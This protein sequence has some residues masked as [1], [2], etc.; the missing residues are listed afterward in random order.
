MLYPESQ[1][2]LP[3]SIP[4][5]ESVKAVLD[6]FHS[7]IRRL[8]DE[9]WQEWL[10]LPFRSRLVF[11][12]RARAVLVFDF[13][14]RRA[15]AEFENDANIRVLVKHRQT[16]QFMFGEKVLVRFK[17]G[18]S[19]GVGSNIETQAVLDFIDPQRTIP[20]LLSDI[21]K[22]EIC[23]QPD[24]IGIELDEV[25]VV[26]RDRRKRIWAYPIPGE[27]PSAIVVELPPQ[28]PDLTPPVV[29]PRKKPDEEEQIEE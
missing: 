21:M 6:D 7:R 28:K 27:K 22:V 4:E 18:N 15:Q 2:M 9:A 16:V 1:G 25:A 17:K 12:E 8:I 24:A 5:P 29:V 23:Y 20:G 14:V 19:K 26:A 3:M 10:G 13:I 11:V